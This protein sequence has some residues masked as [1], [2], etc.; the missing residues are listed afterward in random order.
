M[1]R[2]RKSAFG[3]LV[4]KCF[5]KVLQRYRNKAHLS[6]HNMATKAAVDPKYLYK[7]EKGTSQPTLEIVFRLTD[8]LDLDPREVVGKTRSEIRRNSEP[9]TRSK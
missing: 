1:A 5:G 3:R 6:V 4:G 7:L 2:S 9:E 8:A